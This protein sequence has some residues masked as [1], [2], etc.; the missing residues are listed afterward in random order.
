LWLRDQSQLTNKFVKSGKS[1]FMRGGVEPTLAIF[2]EANMDGRI[3]SVGSGGDA[4][5]GNAFN[6]AN[7]NTRVVGFD[8][9]ALSSVVGFSQ[10]RTNRNQKRPDNA[11]T[12]LVRQNTGDTAPE[13]NMGSYTFVEGNYFGG[14]GRSGGVFDFLNNVKI[15]GTSFIAADFDPTALD[16][17]GVV[18]GG[19]RPGLWVGHQK[20]T[21]VISN[22]TGKA[23]D[24]FQAGNFNFN[25][26]GTGG[27]TYEKGASLNG[28]S[29]LFVNIVAGGTTIHGGTFV[30]SHEVGGSLRTLEY[31]DFD[32]IGGYL[33]TYGGAGAALGSPGVVNIYDGLFLGGDAGNVTV[34]GPEGI[35]VSV[36]GPGLYLGGGGVTKLL[37][38]RYE[39]GVSGKA[40]IVPGGYYIIP[41][42]AR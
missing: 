14:V 11:V 22:K 33:S 4:W 41:P 21:L 16:D 27:G 20:G 9:P 42:M 38:G 18:S 34:G 24:R 19:A 35:A 3:F 40:S 37:G 30:G 1:V 28:G 26:T 32:T 2:I 7:N 29:G 31:T 36:G 17:E 23:T 10:D 25:S 39:A 5:Y 15:E 12:I 8:D 13:K 6:F